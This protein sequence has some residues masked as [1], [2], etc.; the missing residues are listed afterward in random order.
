MNGAYKGQ[1]SLT[2]L[3]SDQQ[4]IIQQNEKSMEVLKNENKYLGLQI[5]DL[6]NELEVQK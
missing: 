2:Q 1:E 4:Q 3:V 5:V 6:K